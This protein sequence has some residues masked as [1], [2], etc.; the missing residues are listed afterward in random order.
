MFLLL[1]EFPFLLPDHYI[2]FFKYFMFFSHL[3]TLK[4][5]TTLVATDINDL[6]LPVYR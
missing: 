1:E 6:K 4:L 2:G 3:V 5:L